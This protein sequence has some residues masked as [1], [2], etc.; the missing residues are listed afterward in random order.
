MNYYIHSM[1]NLFIRSLTEIYIAPLQGYYSEAL[2]TLARLKRKF[3][4]LSRMCRKEP[5]GAISVPKGSPFHTE[6]PTTENGR[7]WLVEVREKGT[8]SNP[9]SIERRELRPL[10]AIHTY[11]HTYIYIHIYIINVVFIW[12]HYR[13]KSSV[14]IQTKRP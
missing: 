4:G 10:V 3:S 11:I 7:V 6:G 9:C 5:W 12:H 13:K 2:P 14:P 1:I 8:K